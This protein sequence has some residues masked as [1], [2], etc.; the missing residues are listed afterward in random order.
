MYFLVFVSTLDL[1]HGHDRIRCEKRTRVRSGKSMISFSSHIQRS[2][3]HKSTYFSLHS[4]I[5]KAYH[6]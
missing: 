2:D 3:C 6:Q 1:Y 4:N 5:A